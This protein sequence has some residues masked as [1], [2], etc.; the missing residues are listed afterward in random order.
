M[1]VV[2]AMYNRVAL[3]CPIKRAEAEAKKMVVLPIQV[4]I[5]LKV[6][7]NWG[8]HPV[9]ERSTLEDIFKRLRN[10]KL[11]GASH[12]LLPETPDDAK[13]KGH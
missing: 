2:N 12:V 13:Y 9:I 6:V 5:G 10:G 8:L 3:C 11:D 1:N 4:C 7:R